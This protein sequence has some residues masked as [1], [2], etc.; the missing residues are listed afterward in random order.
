MRIPIVHSDIEHQLVAHGSS[1]S[2]S[3]SSGNSTEGPSGA[4]SDNGVQDVFG[5]S[6]VSATDSDLSTSSGSNTE[7]PSRSKK[8]RRVAVHIGKDVVDV[9]AWLKRLD[10]EGWTGVVRTALLCP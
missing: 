6:V 7:T 8:Y 4:D 1:S 3:N 10:K 2:S 5:G 9:D